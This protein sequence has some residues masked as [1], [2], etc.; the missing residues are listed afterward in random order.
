MKAH[1]RRSPLALT[2]LPL[3]VLVG[4]STAPKSQSANSSVG[5][6]GN[7]GNHAGGKGGATTKGGTAATGAS[8]SGTAGGAS[9]A[10]VTTPPSVTLSTARA[11]IGGRLGNELHIEV[12]GTSEVGQLASVELLLKDSSGNEVI[13][14]DSNWDGTADSG[15]GR[16]VPDS[17]PTTKDYTVSVMV[18][19]AAGMTD[20]TQIDVALV[21]R[22]N[23]CTDPITV[24]V[25][26][27]TVQTVDQ[28]CDPTFVASRCRQGLSC[29]GSPPVCI[30]GTA[31][32]IVKGAYQRG[33]EGP[34]M[35]ARGTDP[36]EDVLLMRVDFLTANDTPVKLDLDADGIPESTS[37]EVQVGMSNQNGGFT[38]VVESSSSF[39]V[40]VPKVGLTAIDS[41]LNESSTQ[42]YALASRITR[43]LNAACDLDGFDVCPAGALCL[44]GKAVGTAYCTSNAQA[45]SLRCV[46]APIWN[47]A[48]DAKKITGTISGYSAWD[49]PS[50]CLTPVSLNRPEAII[51]MHVTAPIKSLT[52]STDEPETQSDTVLYVQPACSSTTDKV[53]ICNDDTSGFAS[54]VTLTN[55]VAG[56]YFVIVEFVSAQSGGFGLR[57]KVN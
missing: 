21:D 35:R 5:S 7:G 31:P 34:F 50:S 38:F 12:T 37:F 14:F 8:S 24:E 42:H 13:H 33:T 57:A 46:T 27:P 29:T 11:W 40:D 52:L 47:I 6:N 2:V 55:L 23:A 43:Q 30:A 54:S 20:L 56:D 17:P 39:G 44:P 19:G 1:M 22:S 3:V 26:T 53:L 49:A 28:Q 36:D 10:S 15:R 4:C 48:T 51:K 9:G 41:K 32:A 16:V 25:T 45:Q 18:L